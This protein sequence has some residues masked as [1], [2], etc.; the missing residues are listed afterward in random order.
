M[1]TFELVAVRVSP[2]NVKQPLFSLFL[3]HTHAHT[4]ALLYKYKLML[5][6][7]H[8]LSLSAFR[9]HTHNCL[10]QWANAQLVAAKL[11]QSLRKHPVAF[12]CIQ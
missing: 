9:E 4:C 12:Y 11:E 7:S 1:W 2:P 3:S 6:H 8:S 5:T 10:K